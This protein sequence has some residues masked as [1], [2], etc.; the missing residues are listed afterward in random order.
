MAGHI[1]TRPGVDPATVQ[2]KPGPPPVAHETVE[3]HGLLLERDA[4]VELRDG[5]TIRVDVYRPLEDSGPLPVLLAWGPY[6]KHWTQA[7][8]FP[9]SGVEDG[10]ISE[11]TGFEAPDP[12]YW[13]AHGYA[14]AFADP[15]GLWNSE[16]TFPHNGPQERDDLYDTIEWL[17]ARPWSNGRVGMLGVSYLA[18]SQYQAAAAR[19]PSL[20]AISPW[21]CFSDW[22]REFA[23]HGGIP[24]TGFRPRVSANVSYSR[25]RTED[26]AAN[27]WAHPLDDEY[28]A[29]K[30]GA[31]EDV[32]VP[33]YVVASWSDHGL[34]SRGTLEFFERIGSTDKWLE[35]HGRKKWR[36]FY[37]PESVERQRAFFDTYLLD[38]DRGLDAWPAVRMDVR[39]GTEP[40]DWE[41]RSLDAWPVSVEALELQLDA[42]SGTMAPAVAGGSA[43]AAAPAAVPA[44]VPAPAERTFD[45]A[46][47]SADF[48]WTVDRDVELVGPMA[49]SIE[50]SADEA[51][52]ADVFVIVRKLDAAGDEVAF[53]FNALF[54]DGPV[55]LGW[56]RASHRELDE[57][58]STP[59][60]PV[61]PHTSESPL[62]PGEPV[63]L[64]IE[65]WP[66]GTVLH[67][68]ETLLLTIQGRDFVKRVPEVGQ[69]P[70]QILHEELRNRGTWTI[71][72]GA[73]QEAVL[74][75]PVVAPVAAS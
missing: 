47:S 67:A 63:R 14:V 71:R 2:G 41:V 43:G 75:V 13:C 4:P 50:L 27:M 68:G 28:Y 46:T 70:L 69:P 5:A 44:A 40:S 55:A 42:A 33:A 64:D 29:D 11:L 49:L 16:G 73:G 38:V 8:M 12:A 19:P 52:D 51:D 31:F 36:H 61:H 57:A 22:Y 35:V 54:H 3:T 15:R 53:P 17:A 25:H 59:L 6:G 32:D 9:G 30:Y 74:R 65:V 34:H 60:R 56:L 62:T 58:A 21:E 48:R 45:P 18:G 23:T 7:R 72:T 24:E 26:T 1:I 37:D 66:S 20:R 39:D 10:W